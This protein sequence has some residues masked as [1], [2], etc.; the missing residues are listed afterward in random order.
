MPADPSLKDNR[1]SPDALLAAANT[2]K[3]GRLKVFLG[4][5]PGVGK[6]YAMLEDAR[7]RKADGEDVAIGIVETHGRRETEAL[8]EGLEIIARR[9]VEY[10][11]QMLEEFDIDAALLRRP[12]LLLIDELAHTN[13]A[14]SRHPKRY[15]D[16]E[17]VLD[18]GIDVYTTLN[19]QHLESLNDVVARITRIRV[20]ETL[21]DSVLE[22]AN[23]VELVDLTPE[24]LIRRLEEGKVYVPQ[25]AKRAVAR[26]FQPGNLAA[27]R[28][29][30][31]RRTAERVDDQMV[32]Y[33]RRHAIEGPWAAG[34]RI[35]VCVSE[36][37]DS[38]RLV[39]SARRMADM[40]GAKWTAVY[41]E[42]PRHNRLGEAERDN[43]AAALRLAESLG[44]EA[45]TI[46]GL[47]L[48]QELLHYARTHNITQI[49]MG[50]ARRARWRDLLQR[51]LVHEV[52]QQ[53]QGI[54]VH[55]LT[56][57]PDAASG[58]KVPPG[59]V[60]AIDFQPYLYAALGVAVMGAIAKVTISVVDLDNLSMLFLVPVLVSATRWGL[61]PSIFTS[62]LSALVFN[63]FFI[64]PL[65]SL[66]ITEP[67]EV[68]S[69]LIFLLVAILA[70][71]VAGRVRDQAA[72]ARR[73]VKTM[74]AL[75]DFSRKL[76]ATSDLDDLL[77]AVAFQVASTMNA[78]VVILLPEAGTLTLKTGYP[79]E[80]V[81][82]AGG[83]A[84]ANWAWQHSEVTGRGS[85][86]LPSTPW[87]FRPMATD[88]GIAG[89]IGVAFHDE[90]LARDPELMRLLEALVQ[91]A[92]V[93][94]SRA[95]LDQ[96][97]QDSR[98]KT[99][100]DKLRTALF[101]SISH[102][103]RTPL[104]SILGSVT[105]LLADATS[106]A[107]TA[108]DDLLHTIRDEAERLNRFVGNLLDMTRLESGALALKRD[109]VD[110]GELAGS[111][112]ARA[113]KQLEN[114]HVRPQIEPGLP[115]L[116]LDFVLME[117]V[118][119]NVL[120]NA[121][122][123]SP[124]FSTVTIEA[125]REGDSVVLT[126]S[127]EG[128]GIPPADLERVFDKFYRVRAGDK[129]IAGTGLGLSICRGIVE[130]HGGTIVAH[131][132]V[133]GERGTAIILRLGVPPQPATE[134]G[135]S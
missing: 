117:Q 49:V 84:A 113:A 29:L 60:T 94:V 85:G 101:S 73:R 28:E 134:N 81:L 5:A 24:D 83:W 108:R 90:A 9:P 127:D 80:D 76:A 72:V 44:G 55:V 125:R 130:A 95:R 67:E 70:S 13:A 98:V 99:E 91:Q 77:W 26:Y 36:A 25:Q 27:L 50:R 35:M 19:V 107:A 132:P 51:S 89:V 133:Q 31:L 21:P 52:L 87:N 32:A 57:T 2:E 47:D 64:E 33:M 88:Q 128:R 20:R 16:V 109:W 10:R 56:A 12:K 54:A 131:S 82:D 110:V 116:Q 34:E 74:T 63:L 66:T 123:H 6:T 30:A 126:I 3:R 38:L 92:A 115:L 121:A 105:S 111:A 1:P 79:P 11:G 112:I 75:Y 100:S 119:F 46:P 18:A 53:G 8:I 42:M 71:N 39:R 7:R 102:D 22:Q 118:L 45:V 61:W 120:D 65:Y 59:P 4:A 37:A 14:G 86:T 93:G 68:L 62:L 122:K 96:E 15:Q 103:L 48:P 78:R 23:E 41:V 17:E 114:L 69:L 124:P 43:I 104:A 106:L 135:A 58:D 129:Q 97:I 40:L